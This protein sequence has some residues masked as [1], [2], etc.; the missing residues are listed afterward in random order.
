MNAI[1]NMEL[2]PSTRGLCLTAT[3]PILGGRGTLPDNL[4]L[5]GK[6][7]R[8]TEDQLHKHCCAYS[9][10]KNLERNKDIANSWFIF[11]LVAL[12]TQ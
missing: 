8:F 10:A 5:F 4:R 7:E 1:E 3:F 9:C 6:N 2:P 12:V 11:P